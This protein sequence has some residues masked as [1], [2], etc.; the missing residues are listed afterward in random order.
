[1]SRLMNAG[2]MRLMKSKVLLLGLIM[3]FYIDCLDILLDHF[4]GDGGTT[5]PE[6][7]LVSSFITI[8]ILAAV[9]VSS[10]L[11]SEHSFG[12]I[13]NKLVIGHGRIKVYLSCFLVC[14]AGVLMMYVLAWILV[15]IF[16]NLI[17]GGFTKSGAELSVIFL[18][19]LLLMMVI[20]AFYVAIS[21]C[22]QSK[23]AGTAVSILAA[24]VL[25]MIGIMAVQVLSEPEYIS[26]ET[27][28]SKGYAVMDPEPEQTE[29]GLVKN[30]NALLSGS[31]RKTYELIYDLCPVSSVLG[32]V[33]DLSGKNVLIPFGEF[34]ILLAGGLWIFLK[35]DL[36]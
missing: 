31:R 34:V 9:F 17:M 23:S 10:F 8:L 29:D 3:I 16:G 1:M 33:T 21:L 22:I 19:S 5:T 18:L 15:A 4:S 24:F 25:I 14:L 36:R 2:F 20:T 32:E 27:Y 7:Y 6:G 28:Y 26:V 13:R 30:P 11:G 35:R 12:T